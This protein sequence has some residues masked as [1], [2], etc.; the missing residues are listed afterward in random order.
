MN[1]FLLFFFSYRP[2]THLIYHFVVGT[3]WY[4]PCFIEIETAG[5]DNLSKKE[6]LGS[7]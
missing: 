3:Y 4:P 1:Y 6:I 5:G 7:L 2:E